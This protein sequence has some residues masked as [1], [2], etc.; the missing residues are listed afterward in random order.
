[1][2][3]QQQL[4]EYRRRQAERFKQTEQHEESEESEEEREEVKQL[5]N[6]MDEQERQKIEQMDL[7]IAQKLERELNFRT[8]YNPTPD[9]ERAPTDYPNE[10]DVGEEGHPSS[11]PTANQP[12]YFN[13]NNNLFP[14]FNRNNEENKYVKQ[15]P[16]K[17]LLHPIKL[18]KDNKVKV[19]DFTN[20]SFNNELRNTNDST[21]NY[22]CEEIED[23]VLKHHNIDDLE[24]KFSKKQ[25]RQL[26]RFEKEEE[27]RIEEAK[28]SG[29]IIEF[30]GRSNYNYGNNRNSI[31]EPLLGNGQNQANERQLENPIPNNVD[32]N[33]PIQERRVFLCLYLQPNGTFRMC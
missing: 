16:P 30:P 5:S 33:I 18:N 7:E 19:Y 31:S 29:S 6:K 8:N 14:D 27:K 22:E 13:T 15:E 17:W 12:P 28:R 3:A 11:F 10:E 21:V 4:E 1:M 9:L 24:D 32:D 25:K 2:N 26:K 23:P 20:G